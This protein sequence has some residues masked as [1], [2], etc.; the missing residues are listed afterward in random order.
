MKGVLQ[1]VIGLFRVQYKTLKMCGLTTYDLFCGYII[2]I[3]E[4]SSANI[5]IKALN[6]FVS[7]IFQLFSKP[8]VRLLKC[9]RQQF[10]FEGKLFLVW[11]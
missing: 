1:V 3:F 11:E 2:M 6:F 10:F 7:Y 4:P 5:Q 9:Q 8:I